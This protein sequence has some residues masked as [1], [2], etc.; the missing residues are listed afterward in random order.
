MRYLIIPSALAI[1]ALVKAQ[2]PPVELRGAVR[3]GTKPVAGA[4][5][6]VL[7]TLDGAITDSAGAF[8]I[9][10]TRQRSYLIT[11]RLTGYRETRKLVP[12]SARAFITIEAERA[13][14]RALGTVTIEAGR[15]VAADEPGATLSPLEIVTIPGTAANVNRA[16]QTLPGVQQVDE[17]TGLF[18]RGGDFTETRVFLND[19]LLLN[20]A[21]LQS[22]AGTFVGTFDPFL[23]DAVYFTSGG[24]G[25]RYG[26]ALSAVAALRT[27]AR[28]PA[29]S[30]TLSAGLA[31]FAANVALAGPSRTGLR[32]TANRND[33]AP[34]LRVNGSTRQFYVAPHGSDLTASAYWDYRGTG[35]LSVFATQQDGS[36]GALNETPSTSD[37]FAV[38]RRDRALV[39][40]WH[41]LFGRLAPTVTASSS[42]IH[43]DES[44]GAF[45]LSSPQRLDQIETF[46][47]YG[48]TGTTTLRAGAEASR[49]TSTVAGSIPASGDDQAPGA[50]VRVYQTEGSASR[51]GAFAEMDLRPTDATRLIAGL[52]T[53]L[54]SRATARTWDPRVSTAWRVRAGVTLTAAWGVYHQSVDPLLGVLHDSGVTPLASARATQ[55]ILGAQ[56]GDS[57]VSLRVE[58]YDKRYADLAQLTRDFTTATRGTGT[59]RGVDVMAKTPAIAGFSS[60]LVY[61]F[62]DARRTDPSTGLTARAPFDV[63]HSTTLVCSQVLPHQVSLAASLR[64]ASGR[65]FTPVTGAVLDMVTR[66]YAPTYG[67]PGSLRLPAYA[68]VDLSASIFRILKPGRQFVAYVA[69]TNVLGRANVYTWRYSADYTKR[70][71]VASIFN[72]SV[73]FG[74]VLTFTGQR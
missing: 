26:D 30:A 6:F 41:D 7:G 40:A 68:R 72:R 63:T 19:A 17:G 53:D 21:Q 62:V 59:A 23:L 43:K 64:Y 52:R 65:P 9:T 69:L 71:E 74:G 37:T 33:L 61:S 57:G 3:V 44:F 42:I 27:Q 14:E 8:R 46:W 10:T 1:A 18:V 48:A 36:L 60:R 24:F 45:Q 50:R 66:V 25:A 32:L 35:R 67:D 47:E 73:Y 54:S 29:S 51:T 38:A 56:V 70:Y 55:A 34:V 31:A 2:E 22:P 49:T 58:V 20:P 39:V 13:K 16:I 15:Y 28:P 11:L 12:D 4:N 5:V